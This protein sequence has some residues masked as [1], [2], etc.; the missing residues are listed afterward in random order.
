MD[1]FEYQAITKDRCV[2][3]GVAGCD[4]RSGVTRLGV[5]GYGWVT[6]AVGSHLGFQLGYRGDTN[7]PE[8]SHPADTVARRRDAGG[9]A[10]IAAIVCRI[11]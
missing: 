4:A 3:L 9:G 2:L 1:L 7:P 11:A 8:P 6:V 5:A 10:E